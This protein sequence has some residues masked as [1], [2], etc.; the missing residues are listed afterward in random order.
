MVWV[1]VPAFP[2]EL[3]KSRAMR[4]KRWNDAH[5]VQERM[6]ARPGHSCVNISDSCSTRGTLL[7]VGRSLSLESVNKL[8]TKKKPGDGF[9]AS[10]DSNRNCKQTPGREWVNRANVE[11][12]L[13]FVPSGEK[14]GQTRL[15]GQNEDKL[16]DRERRERAGNDDWL[17]G[18]I[19]MDL[20]LASVFEDQLKVRV[21]GLGGCPAIVW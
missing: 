7:S 14:K 3:S 4:S 18:P 1:L 6:N 13:E 2:I 17:R 21:Q 10:G 12:W 16:V 19:P 5:S 11:G 20:L 9:S 15:M 8:P